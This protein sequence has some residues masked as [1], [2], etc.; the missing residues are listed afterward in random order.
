MWHLMKGH[1]CGSTVWQS[2][3]K[4]HIDDSLR[5]VNFLMRPDVVQVRTVKKW[6]LLLPPRAPNYQDNQ[7]VIAAYSN[8]AP[9]SIRIL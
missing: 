8:I 6:D 3:K 9:E 7:R 4:T 2:V 1:L 5:L